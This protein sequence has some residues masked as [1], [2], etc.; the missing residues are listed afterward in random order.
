MTSCP[1]PAGSKE[2]VETYRLRAELCIDI[3]SPND[4]SD[5]KVPADFSDWWRRQQGFRTQP[6]IRC[7]EVVAT[8]GHF[9]LRVRDA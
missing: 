8:P 6:P 1:H 9:D 5:Q 4:A 3:F 2:R 7:Y